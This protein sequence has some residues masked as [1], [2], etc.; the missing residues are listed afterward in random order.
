MKKVF[1]FNKETHKKQEKTRGK[2]ERLLKGHRKQFPFVIF[3]QGIKKHT[4]DTNV[5]LVLHA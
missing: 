2:G 4:L 3:S 1:L 5:A